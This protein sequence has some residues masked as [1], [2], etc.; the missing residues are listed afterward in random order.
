MLKQSE[1]HLPE[2]PVVGLGTGHALA[3]LEAEGARAEALLDAARGRYPALAVRLGDRISRRWLEKCGNPYL[4]EV[5]A[6]ARRLASPGAYFLNV[7]HEWGCTSAVGPV[8]DGIGTRLIR[9]LDWTFDGLGVNLVAARIAGPAGPWINLTWPGFVGCVQGLA[10]GR[11][12]AAFHQ[13]PMRRRTPV[14]PLDWV[15]NRAGVWRGIGLPPAHLL[16]RAFETCGD[17]AAARTLLVEA[18]LALPTIFVLSGPGPGE[19]CVI[20]RLE[21]R[22]T[23]REQPAAAANHWMSQALRAAPRGQDSHARQA[24]MADRQASAGIDFAWLRAPVLNQT[25]RLVMIAEPARGRLVARGYEADGPATGVLALEA[26][27]AG[28]GSA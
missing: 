16:R 3:L 26:A 15:L 19:G 24:M 23:V 28:P 1:R 6:V 27:S 18:P 9:V 11:F 5:H 21:D 12:A 20:E 8:R 17:Y 13:A 2:I 4:D 22:A 10:P 14:M 25:T 7:N